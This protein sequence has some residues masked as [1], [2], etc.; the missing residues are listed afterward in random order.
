VGGKRIDAASPAGKASRHHRRAQRDRG[1]DTRLRLVEAAVDVFGLYGFEGATTRQI[2]REAGANLAAIVYHFGS[3]E[4]LHTAVAEHVAKH[5]FD[6]VGPALAEAGAAGAAETPAAARAM[7]HRL[8]ETYVDVIV[9]TADAERWAR[10]IVREQMQPSG[11]F[12]V[13][14]R[15][16]GGALALASR[17][18]A[19]AL[20]RPEDDSVRLRTLTLFGQV[21]I[22]RVAQAM[23]LRR[24]GWA[25]IGPTE[26]AEIK[27][28]VGGQIDAIIDR[29]MR[30]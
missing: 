12:D 3:K 26:R 6:A 20:G 4:A 11:A 18:L 25:A 9:G 8:I 1:A 22:F 5:M 15:V 24:L 29:E 2:A 21:L 16:M 23:V 14:Y 13:I 27:H 10:F 30:V 7:L 28:I 17:L 19:A